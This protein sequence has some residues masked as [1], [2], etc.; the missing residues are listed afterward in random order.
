M[1]GSLFFY[2]GIFII[3]LVVSYWKRRKNKTVNKCRLQ[4]NETLAN[5]GE[6]I[7]EEDSKHFKLVQVKKNQLINVF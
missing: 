7:K 6:D 1:D 2:I 5:I 3:S 4:T